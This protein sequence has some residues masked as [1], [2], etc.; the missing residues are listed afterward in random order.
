[1]QITWEHFA[2]VDRVHDS[3]Q[4]LQFSIF[5]IIVYINVLKAIIR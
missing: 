4:L 3:L 5:K 2:F 1:M